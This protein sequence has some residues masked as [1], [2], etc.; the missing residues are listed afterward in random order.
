[1]IRENVYNALFTILCGAPGLV[2]K[3]RRL[4]HWTDVPVAQQ[5]AL[6][7]VRKSETAQR[8]SNKPCIWICEVDVYLYV[9]QSN[10]KRSPDEILNPILD[11]ITTVMTA[12]M[13]RNN[14]LGGLAYYARIEGTIET[15]EGALGNQAAAIIPIR[16]LTT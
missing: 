15:D 8:E 1:M 7:M 12:P 2:T 6:F 11:Y 9:N 14:D 16:I 5:P 3:S 13:G 4:L 10:A